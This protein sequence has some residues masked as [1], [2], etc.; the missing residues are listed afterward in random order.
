MAARSIA[1]GTICFGLVS[2]PVRVYASTDA[3]ASISFHLLHKKCGTRLKQQY[4]CPKD[5]GDVVSRP[6]MVKGFEFAKEQYV[7][8]SDDE[9][10]ELQEPPT[11]SIDITEFLGAEK[12]PPIYFQKSY[13]LGPDKGG[14]RAYR[15]LS[16][17]MRR[18]ARVA[19]AKYAA[20]G[21]QYLVMISPNDGEGLVLYQ[22]Y[23]ADEVRSFSEVPVGEGELK[24]SELKLAIELVNQITTESFHPEKYEDEVKKRIE[25]VIQRKVEGKEVTLAPP[26]TPRAEIIDLMDAL[27]ASL[28]AGAGKPSARAKEAPSGRRGPKQAPRAKTSS[29]KRAEGTEEQ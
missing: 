10:K 15:L 4:V 19:L 8:F 27:K 18:T 14:D 22:L 20:R 3:G 17:T 5:G 28:A 24:E 2:I 25:Q 21:K 29:K 26:E 9:L 7:V 23:Y 11:Q 1:S 16:E 13:Y 12:V 6:E